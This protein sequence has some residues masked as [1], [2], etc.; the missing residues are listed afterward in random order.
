MKFLKFNKGLILFQPFPYDQMV[1]SG[2][3]WKSSTYRGAE[4]RASN[5]YTPGYAPGTRY[6]VAGGRAGTSQ[7]LASGL[8]ALNLNKMSVNPD[9]MEAAWQAFWNTVNSSAANP[10]P[11]APG[12]T[13]W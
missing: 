3:Q 2:S 12:N 5:R 6:S 1:K 10:P 11:Q 7:A 9:V 8:D 4:G 13:K